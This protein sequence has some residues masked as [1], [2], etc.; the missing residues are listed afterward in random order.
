MNISWDAKKYEEV[1]SFVHKYGEDVLDMITLP[2]GRESYVV[3]LGC[4]NGALT[5]KIAERG[6][7]VIGIDDSEDMLLKA[8][9]LHPS[10]VFQK[11]SFAHGG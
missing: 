5:Q 11:S 2:A 10:L 8:A 7:R 4:G 1:F 3:D 6:M 9:G